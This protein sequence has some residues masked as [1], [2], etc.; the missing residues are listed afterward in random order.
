MGNEVFVGIDTA[1]AHTAIAVAEAGRDAEVHYLGTFD[2]TPDAATRL[3]RKLAGRYARRCISAM[4]PDRRDTGCIGRSCRT[5][6][7]KRSFLHHASRYAMRVL[8][9]PKAMVQNP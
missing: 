2:K 5:M 4:K 9:V 3:V 7:Q 6:V 8:F 1:K